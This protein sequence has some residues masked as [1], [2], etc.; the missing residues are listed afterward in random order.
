MENNFQD[1]LKTLCRDFL[2]SY[3]EYKDL[4]ARIEQL[5]GVMGM[6]KDEIINSF[7]SIGIKSLDIDGVKLVKYQATHPIVKD[8]DALKSYIKNEWGEPLEEYM[9]EVFDAKKLKDLTDTLKKESVASNVSLESLMPD[10]LEI[11][12]TQSIQVRGYKKDENSP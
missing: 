8:Y 11:S 3:E 1:N 7:D 9:K 4:E 2:S 12:V 6:Q 10:G 5:K